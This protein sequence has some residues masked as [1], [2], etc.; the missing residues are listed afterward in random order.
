MNQLSVS[1]SPH[2]GTPDNTRS[3]MLDVIVALSL[4]SVFGIVMFGWHAALCIA[5]C[6]GSCVLFEY[7]GCKAFGHANSIGDLSA[8]VTGLLLALNLPPL[9][10]A[11]IWIAVIGSF[12]A[13]FVV[14]QM[15]G[16]LG[17]NFVNPAIAARIIL[18]ISFPGV[19]TT[20][21]EPL[22]ANVVTSATP[23]AVAGQSGQYA[24]SDLIFGI[25]GGC[26][27]ETS[28]VFLA[29]GGLYLLIRGVISPV[30]PVSFIGSVALFSW[31]FGADPLY[32]VCS[33]G[34]ML[35]ALF[36]ATDYVTSPCTAL[37]KLIFGIGCG[38]LTAVI[39]SGSAAEGVS[40]AIL[41]MNLL[42][43]HIDRITVK[44]PFAWEGKPRE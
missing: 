12:A 5:V 25:H 1:P 36:M 42:V 31:I 40:F 26:I 20:F 3:I 44:K 15:F 13:I 39:R 16:G 41:F 30:I 38:A 28:V 8:V 27:G 14:K 34:V 21:Y 6:V 23:L 33:G 18:L 22:R 17:H 35:G 37:G 9:R 7:L 24:I 43:P 11:D 2:L 10:L 4:P 29:V 19:M 32:A